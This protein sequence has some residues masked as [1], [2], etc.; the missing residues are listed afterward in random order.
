MPI[1]KAANSNRRNCNRRSG[2]GRSKQ[3][4]SRVSNSSPNQSRLA[5]AK[6]QYERHTAR[7]RDSAAK[8]DII[9][10]EN[11]YQHAEHYLRQMQE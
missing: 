1:A 7:A 3:G 2:V 10:A 8:G 11:H 4:S 5:N 9:E 6:F